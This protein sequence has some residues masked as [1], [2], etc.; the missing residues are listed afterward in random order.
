MDKVIKK[1]R[2]KWGHRLNENVVK[3]VIDKLN[4]KYDS[5][6]KG[7][8]GLVIHLIKSFLPINPMNRVYE[9]AEG[10]DTICCLT[11]NRLCSVK[12]IIDSARRVGLDEKYIESYDLLCDN[13]EADEEYV[14]LIDE[15]NKLSIHRN[16]IYRNIKNKDYAFSSPNTSMVLCTEAI[17]ALEEFVNS[18]I[19]S[20]DK[21][22]KKLI[23]ETNTNSKPSY[24]KSNKKQSNT[25]ST[26]TNTFNK[27]YTSKDSSRNT[28]KSFVNDKPKSRDTTNIPTNN[29][30]NVVRKKPTNDSINTSASNTTD[31]NNMG[32]KLN[33]LV[34][35]YNKH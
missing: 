12:E 10:D 16:N 15:Y 32:Y 23:D 21:F 6:E 22:I 8:R 1:K 24:N 31:S 19:N 28:N 34:N 35:K 3:S 2:L 4:D 20:G 11:K 30:N 29:R 26:K 17:V 9:F 14:K 13:E 33:Q 5:N 18:K 27:K 25:D 7:G